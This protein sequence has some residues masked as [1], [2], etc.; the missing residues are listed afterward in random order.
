M[1]V[2]SP[3]ADAA[4][5]LVDRV[6]GLPPLPAIALRLNELLARPDTSALEVASLL[7]SDPAVAARV[8]RIANSASHGCSHRIQTLAHAIMVLGFGAVR[9]V[10][11]AMTLLRSLESAASFR[12]GE[13]RRLWRSAVAAGAAAKVLAARRDHAHVEELFLMGLIHDVGRIVLRAWLPEQAARIDDQVLA[14]VPRAEAE[15]LRLETTHE[16]IGAALLERWR[17]PPAYV[18][19]ARVHHDPG[20]AR[21][22]RGAAAIVHVADVLAAALLF[23]PLPDEPAP[24]LS[25]EAWQYVGLTPASLPGVLRDILDLVADAEGLLLPRSVA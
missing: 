24:P 8:L 5:D 1:N 22:H 17:L 10:V 16:E 20:L 13:Q 14:G 11:L 9:N 3:A 12:P 25:R 21:E 6:E 19:V 15:L 2:A 18:E 4:R 23:G 7:G